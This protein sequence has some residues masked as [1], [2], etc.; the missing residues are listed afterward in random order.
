MFSQPGVLT[1]AEVLQGTDSWDSLPSMRQPAW[2]CGIAWRESQAAILI[3]EGEISVL[4]PEGLGSSGALRFARSEVAEVA[5]VAE[6]RN[7][8]FGGKELAVL[9][10]GCCWNERASASKLALSPCL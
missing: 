4:S 10:A 9:T 7:W 8:R 5:E 2:H 1:V 3:L 6:A